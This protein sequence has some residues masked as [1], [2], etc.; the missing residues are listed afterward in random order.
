MNCRIVGAICPHNFAQVHIV[1]VCFPRKEAHY[2]GKS[3]KIVTSTNYFI[4]PCPLAVNTIA[5]IENKTTYKHAV[6]FKNP[7]YP[8]HFRGSCTRSDRV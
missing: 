6:S 7:E 8:T 3:E 2:F 1:L 5:D 4:H